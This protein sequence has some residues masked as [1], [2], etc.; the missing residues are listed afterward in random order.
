MRVVN[1]LCCI[2]LVAVVVC[3]SACSEHK[4]KDF[5]GLRYKAPNEATAASYPPLSTPQI[6]KLTP[7]TELKSGRS[8]K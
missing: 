8:Q 2:F 1:P 6:L 5:F 7:S 3:C 4:T